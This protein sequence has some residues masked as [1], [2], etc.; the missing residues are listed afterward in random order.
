MREGTG[1]TGHLVAIIIMKT[2][3]WDSA[4]EELLL[5]IFF[6]LD[7]KD[8]ARAGQACRRWRALSEDDV[9]W[10]KIIVRD[11]WI[12]EPSRL[13]TMEKTSWRSEYQRLVDNTPEICTEVLTAHTDEVLHVAFCQSGDRFVTCSK[14]G[15][16]IVWRVR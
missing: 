14:D 5:K 10:R 2:N 13:E 11:F 15:A 6:L 1:E 16:F 7:A 9:L 8:V 3:T 4:P 12:E